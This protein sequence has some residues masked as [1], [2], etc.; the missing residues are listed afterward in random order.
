MAQANRGLGYWATIA[1]GVIIA[2]CGLAIFAVGISMI[3]SGGS[4]HYALIGVGLLISAYYLFQHSMVGV[5]A[6]FATFIGALIWALSDPGFKAWA[7]VPRLIAPTIIL[8][9]V[10]ATIPALC[11]RLS[12]SRDAYATA[13]V[14][15]VTLGLS[16]VVLTSGP[17]QTLF[18]ED[19]SMPA[20]ASA[21][22]VPEAELQPTRTPVSYA[23]GGPQ[24]M[25]THIGDYFIA[26]ALPRG[27]TP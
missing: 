16:L 26:Y 20:G 11:G 6:Y 10:L 5:W 3:G 25:E 9:L 15:V 13:S 23:T 21:I 27:D 2:I 17:D 4:W 22:I 7:E 1:V 19:A 8:V 14:G 12:F 24:F 18:A